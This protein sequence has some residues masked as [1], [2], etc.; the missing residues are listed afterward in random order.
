[1]RFVTV[2]A[3]A[4]AVMT[5]GCG[6]GAITGTLPDAPELPR[7]TGTHRTGTAILHLVDASRGDPVS[8][9]PHRQ[10]EIMVQVWYPAAV[11]EGQKTAPY[12]PNPVVI[13]TMKKEKYYL[14]T[15]SVLDS[16]RRVDTHSV[17]DAPVDGGAALY[18]L[19]IFSPGLGVSRSNY[20]AL[21]EELASHGFVVACVDHP[22]NGVT[23][24]P[25]GRVL[26][27]A[28][29]P[30][31]EGEEAT[32]NLIRAL[33]EDASFVVDHL[34]SGGDQETAWIAQHVDPA[35]IGILGH[36][37]GGAV[38]L[39]AALR[40]ER[41]RASADLDGGPFGSVSEKGIGKPSL[42]L[43]SQPIYSDEDLKKKGRTRQQWENMGKDIEATWQGILLKQPKI[44]AYTASIL[45]TGHMS[46]S[47][48]PFVM[49]DTITRFGG[50]IIDARR[51]FEIMSLYIRAFF[52]QVLEG[53]P[54]TL[55]EG[56]S[57]QNPEVVF[58]VFG[59]S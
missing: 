59:G 18:P 48:A 34:T 22:Y 3:L 14:Q 50:R 5:A 46:F 58:K 13:E 19:L 35:R 20:T 49:P 25:D 15:A 37:N 24:L 40:D 52:G 16:W 1:M 44:P 6:G 26:S 55:L 7:P 31:D 30:A 47:D 42:I 11:T 51:G 38:A 45:G 41:F 29:Y 17:L 53:T 21:S 9:R 43:R 12:I 56:P 28:Q 27:I 57:R 10:R 23:V 4:V 8:K 39:E 32:A 36:S 54:S 33:A 2:G